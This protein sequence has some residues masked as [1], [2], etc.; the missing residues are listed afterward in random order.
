MNIVRALLN[1]ERLE[2]LTSMDKEPGRVLAMICEQGEIDY[3]LKHDVLHD[4][5]YLLPFTILAVP[6]APCICCC[7]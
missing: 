7:D 6:E 1:T 3:F 2:L 5:S 4:R